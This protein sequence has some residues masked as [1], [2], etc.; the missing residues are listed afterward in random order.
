MDV[1]LNIGKYSAYQG[2]AVASVGQT[3]S[4]ISWGLAGVTIAWFLAMPTSPERLIPWTFYSVLSLSGLRLR[5]KYW[6]MLVH[7]LR[8]MMH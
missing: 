1:S 6:Q 5:S 4:P 2:T 8:V 7:L 3:S